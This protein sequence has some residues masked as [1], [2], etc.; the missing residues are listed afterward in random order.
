[1]FSNHFGQFFIQLGVRLGATGWSDPSGSCLAILAHLSI[2]GR[3]PH[4]TL[5]RRDVGAALSSFGS[6]VE[7]LYDKNFT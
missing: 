5:R 2:E 6:Y 3:G 4:H 7:N 1:M